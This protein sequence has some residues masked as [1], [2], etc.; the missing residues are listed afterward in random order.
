M[1]EDHIENTHVAQEQPVTF[2]PQHGHYSN[3]RVYQVAEMIYDMTFHF[4]HRFL[5]RGDRT[6]D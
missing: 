5:G 3:L 4:C 2:L 6:V 1:M